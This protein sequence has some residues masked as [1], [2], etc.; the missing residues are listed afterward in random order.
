M[1][2]HIGLVISG[3]LPSST[4][5]KGKYSLLGCDSNLTVKKNSVSD[6]VTV[7]GLRMSEILEWAVCRHSSNSN[8]GS[9]TSE[10]TIKKSSSGMSLTKLLGIGDSSSALPIGDSSSKTNDGTAVS[11]EKAL[12]V[13][14]ALCSSKLKFAMWLAEL[15]YVESAAFYA[16]D[17]RE[18]VNLCSKQTGLS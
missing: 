3:G 2:G 8:I 6:F 12:R 1:A 5:A 10:S 17:V 11:A 13:R 9:K 16:R 18:L 14:I 15:G 7:R 4:V